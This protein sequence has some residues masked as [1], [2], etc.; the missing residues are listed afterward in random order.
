MYKNDVRCAR[1]DANPEYDT[2]PWYFVLLPEIPY[3]KGYP[4]QAV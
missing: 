1:K 4:V 3:R 2:S